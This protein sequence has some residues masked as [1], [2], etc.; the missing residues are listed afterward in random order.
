M[1]SGEVDTV[2]LE[3]GTQ[4]RVLLSEQLVH[5]HARGLSHEVVHRRPEGDRGLVPDPVEGVA[6]DVLVEHLRRFGGAHLLSEPG[7]PGVGV[8]DVDGAPPRTVVVQKLVGDPVVVLVR[9]LVSFDLRNLHRSNSAER[10]VVRWDAA[11]SGLAA[12][13][14]VRWSLRRWCLWAQ[15]QVRTRAGYTA[16]CRRMRP[17]SQNA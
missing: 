16:S 9:N 8:G 13:S 2:Q 11:C 12:D 17:G 10:E 5:R 1:R 14:R 3:T 7:E 15:V 6:A 4:E